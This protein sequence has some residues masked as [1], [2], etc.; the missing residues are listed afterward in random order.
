MGGMVLEGGTFRPI[1][2]CGIMDCLLDNDIM[3]PYIIGVSAG[4]TDGFSYISK[5]PRRNLDVLMNHRHDKRYIGVGNFLKEKSL[6]G[7]KYGFE[8][9]PNEIY[10]FDFDT[11]YASPSKILVG[12]TNAN[13]GKTEYLDGHDVDHACTMIKATCAIPFFFPA[14]E[15]KGEEYFDGGIC[16]PIP[17]R[18]ALSDGNKKVLIILTRPAE[19]RKKLSK[20]NVLA[21]KALHR[22]YPN[23]SSALITRHQHYNETVDYCLELE[24]EGKALVLR[25]TK[26]VAIDSMEGDLDKIKAIYDYG[27]Q[28]ALDHLEEIRNICQS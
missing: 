28:L 11:L 1:F 18:K 15:W 10:P 17:V 21:S 13:T 22:K 7:L 12:V 16:D 6:F 2:S 4:I 3:F 20:A 8:T 27:Y 26:D 23:M 5:Q 24:K 25:P 9:I 14:I 19:Y